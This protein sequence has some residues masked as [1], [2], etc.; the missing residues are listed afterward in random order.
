MTEFQN[1]TEQHD[2][3]ALAATLGDDAEQ[4]R[5]DSEALGAFIRSLLPEGAVSALTG[6]P[7]APAQ[8]IAV[9]STGA[10]ALV[11]ATS[12]HLRAAD[13]RLAALRTLTR[14]V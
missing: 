8:A 9:D 14:E 13:S 6:A 12:V 2:S 7:D 3:H 1:G 5:V 11:A 4:L 10:A